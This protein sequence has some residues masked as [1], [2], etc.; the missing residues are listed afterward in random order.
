[1]RTGAG[2]DDVAA[3]LRFLDGNDHFFLNLSM[4]ACKCALDPAAG[5]PAL[6]A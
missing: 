4:A 5:I 3:V 1:M 2:A 6:D